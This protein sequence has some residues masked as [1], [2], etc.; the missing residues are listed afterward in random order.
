MAEWPAVTGKSTP[1]KVEKD[2]ANNQRQ[3]SDSRSNEAKSGR[4]HDLEWGAK[5]LFTV[6]RNGRRENAQRS[7]TELPAGL[8]LP[9]SLLLEK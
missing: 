1:P 8:R 7:R 2:A 4:P 9:T 5:G 6:A 3:E